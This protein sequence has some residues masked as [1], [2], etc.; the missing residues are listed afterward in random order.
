MSAGSADKRASKATEVKERRER[1]RQDHRGQNHNDEVDGCADD[2]ASDEMSFSVWHRSS[3]FCFGV[4]AICISFF[5]G[6]SFHAGANKIRAKFGD[7][8]CRIER[9]L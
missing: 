8:R 5:T 6:G 3:L 4:S 2:R 1:Q 9:G 7:I